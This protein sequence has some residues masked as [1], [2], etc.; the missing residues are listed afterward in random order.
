[1]NKYIEYIK[2]VPKGIPN[3]NSILKGIVNDVELRHKLLSENNRDEIIRR[4]LICET[5]P[6]N[7]I[8]A[9]TSSEYFILTGNHYRSSR[10]DKHCSF[11]GC[12]INIRT[13]S[14]C[15]DCG[16]EEWNEFNK[17]KSIELKWKAYNDDG[18]TVF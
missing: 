4:R 18:S 6:F 2:L 15:S 3:I 13:A 9:K 16:I 10:K 1:M 8:G 11:C 17:D 7:S 12:P 5:C 14:L